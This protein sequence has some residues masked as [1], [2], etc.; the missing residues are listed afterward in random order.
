M[1]SQGLGT[2]QG[3][4]AI[5]NSPIQHV[6]PHNAHGKYVNFVYSNVYDEPQFFLFCSGFHP[7]PPPLKPGLLILCFSHRYLNS[8]K[9]LVSYKDLPGPALPSQPLPSPPPGARAPELRPQASDSWPER[10]VPVHPPVTTLDLFPQTHH[11]HS[12]SGISILQRL[13]PGAV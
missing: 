8:P 2:P 4:A 6:V 9:H 3:H 7:L 11:G 12:I 13:L 10:L 5:N 1:E